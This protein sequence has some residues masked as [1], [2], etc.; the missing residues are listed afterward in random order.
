MALKIKKI[1]PEIYCALE[2]VVG[3][4]YVSQEPATLD[5]YSFGFGLDAAIGSRP[6]RTRHAASSGRR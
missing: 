4:E 5:S 1:D 6:P 2:D 3:T